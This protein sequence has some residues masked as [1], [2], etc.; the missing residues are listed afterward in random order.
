VAAE[1]A[2]ALR[3]AIGR[4][5]G[6]LD[7]RSAESA[8]DGATLDLARDEADLIAGLERVFD[9]QGVFWPCRR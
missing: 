5:G 9:P 6:S 4:L 3:S 1:A 7:L 8:S 2:A